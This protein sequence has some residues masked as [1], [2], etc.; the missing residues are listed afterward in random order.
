MLK[1]KNEIGL[2]ELSR[3]FFLHGSALQE[4]RVQTKDE[5]SVLLAKRVHFCHFSI[6]GES[7][8][9]LFNQTHFK[10]YFIR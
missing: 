9:N 3:D 1:K 6:S 2:R 5:R 10:T 8:T 4:L 7:I